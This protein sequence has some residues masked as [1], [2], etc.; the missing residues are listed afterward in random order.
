MR[1]QGN[2]FGNLRQLV[3]DATVIAVS[4][5]FDALALHH[6]AVGGRQGRAR[7]HRLLVAI[8]AVE[9]F[10]VVAGNSG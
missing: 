7:G 3:A 10:G 4:D 1:E 8:H 2:A 6:D 5:V 9:A